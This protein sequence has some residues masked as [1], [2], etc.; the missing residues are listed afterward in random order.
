M[1]IKKL[2]SSDIITQIINLRQLTFEVTDACNLKCKYCGYG[3]FYV[4]HDDREDKFLSVNTAKSVIDYIINIWK[5]YSINK[6]YHDTALSFYGGE[7]LMNIKFIKEVIDYAEN[8]VIKG[9][10]FRYTMTTNAVL[11]DRYMDYL[12]EK[13]FRILISLDG[14]EYAHSYR[15][16]HAGNNSFHKVFKNINLL[17]ERHPEYFKEYISFNSVITDR[18]D[19]EKV[20]NFIYKTYG[21]VPMISA[22][23]NSGIKDS[24]KEEFN[25]IFNDV[26]TSVNR[27][28]DYEKMQEE[29]FTSEPKVDGLSKFIQN[30][31]ANWFLDYHSLLFDSSKFPRLATGTCL[32]FQKRM[33]VTVNGKIIQCER[34]DHKYALGRVTDKGVELDFEKI[35]DDYNKRIQSIQ[36]LCSLCSRR[37]FCSQCIYYIENLGQKKIKCNSFMNKEQFEAYKNYHFD[38]LG[39]YP[40][41]YKKIMEEVV[42]DY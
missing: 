7:P 5:N 21:K 11:L 10:K 26:I 14:D 27:S 17:R 22:L 8:N 3:E 18:N 6:H 28:T 38:Y 36:P 42:I 19:V 15:V 9:R 40:H 30:I 25:N 32:P 37:D 39:K 20:H 29:M 34:I 35:A 2:T 41:L 12:V 1:N 13:K 4:G 16:D 24:K 33:F 23:N 31:S